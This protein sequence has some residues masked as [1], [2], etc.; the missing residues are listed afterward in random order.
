MGQFL[1]KMINHP[2]MGQII[3]NMQWQVLDLS[4]CG[5]DLLLS[6]RPAVRISG[7]KKLDCQILFPLSPQKLFLATHKGWNMQTVPDR[8]L[9]KAANRASVAA[10]AARIFTTGE[11]H[12]PLLEKWVIQSRPLLA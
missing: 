2:E 5:T 7:L 8:L 3:V 12:R 6:D 4:E 1:P 10:S 11:H 9:V